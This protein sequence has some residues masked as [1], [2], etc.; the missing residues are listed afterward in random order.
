MIITIGINE[1]DDTVIEIEVDEIQIPVHQI[2]NEI[3][4]AIEEQAVVV[5]NPNQ[6]INITTDRWTSDK[7]QIYKNNHSL[8][9][10]LLITHYGIRYRKGIL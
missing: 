9:R 8:F 1:L 2:D 7:L 6:E 5:V 4:E 3:V 10:S